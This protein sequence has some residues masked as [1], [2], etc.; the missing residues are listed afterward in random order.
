MQEAEIRSAREKAAKD[1]SDRRA[2]SKRRAWKRA[3]R[4]LEMIHERWIGVPG[5]EEEAVE[6][7]TSYGGTEIISEEL[8]EVEERSAGLT[9]FCT[10]AGNF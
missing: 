1:R 4:P 7:Q 9:L 5:H 10:P 3:S 8:A 2:A 6:V